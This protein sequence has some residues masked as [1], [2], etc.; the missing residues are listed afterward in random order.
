MGELNMVE[1]ITGDTGVV[2]GCSQ[3]RLMRAVFGIEPDKTKMLGQTVHVLPCGPL[4]EGV[5]IIGAVTP[6][7]ERAE[8]ISDA[9]QVA[10]KT[11]ALWNFPD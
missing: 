2:Y 1:A 9:P 6:C 4:N 8:S 3:N 5:P 11:R 10:G 7:H